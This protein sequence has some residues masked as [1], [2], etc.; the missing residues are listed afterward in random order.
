MPSVHRAFWSFAMTGLVRHPNV[1]TFD[2]LASLPMQTT[3]AAIICRAALPSTPIKFTEWRGVRL[4]DLL[5]QVE[6]DPRASFARVHS[7]DGYT[8]ILEADVLET[9]MVVI[10]R[11]GNPLTRDD[12]APARLLLS[13]VFG[14][15][16][17]KWIER[18]E[19]IDQ[20]AGGFW[21][22]RGFDLG[23]EIGM[24]I[25]GVQTRSTSNGV[26]ISGLVYGSAIPGS[27]LVSIE[28]GGWMP[29]RISPP[30]INVTSMNITNWSVQW[31][32]P[33]SGTFTARIRPTAVN[34]TETTVISYQFKVV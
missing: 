23:G 19:W 4:S 13:G 6:V 26:E 22:D 2:D 34:D 21:E 32:P 12:G 30:E 9:A 29:A 16:Q 5:A 17:A 7:A 11:D 1:W 31:K 10:E 24:G 15:K 28:E 27:V 25:A 18:I 14:Y 33:H 8:T 20:P 3:R